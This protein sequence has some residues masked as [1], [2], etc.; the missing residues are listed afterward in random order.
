MSGNY[1]VQR[2]EC[3]EDFH[4]LRNDDIVSGVVHIRPWHFSADWVYCEVEA[5]KFLYGRITPTSIA[6]IVLPSFDVFKAHCKV[7]GGKFLFNSIVGGHHN[8]FEACNS[9]FAFGITVSKFLRERGL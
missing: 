3:L 1:V 4:L 8:T 7:K 6:R 2:L 5:E 9:G